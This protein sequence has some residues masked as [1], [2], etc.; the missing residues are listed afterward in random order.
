METGTEMVW[1]MHV[2]EASFRN[3]SRESWSP[4]LETNSSAVPLE[5]TL[6]S[7]YLHGASKDH[8]RNS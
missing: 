8:R 1:S 6:D 2:S 5:K 3:V 7:V 4:S